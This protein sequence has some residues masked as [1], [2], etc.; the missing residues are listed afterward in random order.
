MRPLSPYE[1]GV[2]F[3]ILR[4][5]ECGVLAT[6]P[7]PRQE[8][9]TRYYDSGDY[10]SATEA[11]QV[12]RR[13]GPWLDRVRVL[14]RRSVV[15]RYYGPPQ[16]RRRPAAV[17]ASALARRR[18]GWAPDGL[19]VGRLLD[20]GS[21]D[22]AFL[23]DVV[24]LGWEATGLE[25]SARAAANAA[26]L[27]LDVRV[28]DIRK[29]P[30]PPDSFDVVRLWSV[31]EHVREPLA[32]MRGAARA[33]RPGGW[34][35]VQLPNAEGAAARVFG[36]RWSGWHVPAHL[37][38]FTRASLWRL[39]GDAGLEPAEF[40]HAS[41]GTLARTLRIAGNAAGR[42]GVALVDL[43][44]DAAGAGDSM[45]AFARRPR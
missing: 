4:C 44:L 16:V 41:V 38:H 23:R 43:G 17:I 7:Q 27:G 8:D 9:L 35:V 10:Y 28:G 45:M 18:F 12:G 31:L 40:H 3:H 30:F 29:A 36:A 2:R 24:E 13:G 5:L 21:G 37:W 42:L 6:W 39:L 26:R 14:A 33:L 11:S 32:V 34:A 20:I 25:V 22:G 19:E 1:T 15:G